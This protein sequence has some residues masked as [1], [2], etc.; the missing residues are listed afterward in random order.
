[1]FNVNKTIATA[2]L[3]SGVHLSATAAAGSDIDVRVNRLVAKVKSTLVAMP[4]GSFD[5]GD[6]GTES[7]QYWDIDEDSRPLHKVT[8]DG[9]SM[10]AYKV[11][12]DDFDVFT[13][14]TG[15][16]RVDMDPYY[17]HQRSPRRAA[18]VSWHGASAYCKWLGQLTNL[19]FDLPTEAQW[20][21]AARSGGKRVLFGTDNGKIERGRNY[22]GDWVHGEPEPENPDVGAFPP[23]PAGIYG[24]TEATQ[25][26]VRDWFDENYY[27]KSPE[28]NP[29]GPATGTE[30]VQRGSVGGKPEIAAMVFMRTSAVP[31]TLKTT[32]PN[33]TGRGMVMVP[34]PGYS[35]YKDD[36]FRCVAGSY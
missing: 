3:V 36:N 32:L 18:G 29:T 6:W 10:M 4:G 14:A 26:W 28:L 25:E 31:Q 20:E 33:G 11:T 7:G 8:L 30:K 27:K 34:F 35:S 19:P 17:A 9:F 12:F 2:M 22:P 24:V 13:D 5:M 16:E 21:Y 15:K 23:N 1:M